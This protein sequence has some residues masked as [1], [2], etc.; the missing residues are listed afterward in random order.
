MN[1]EDLKV[2]AKVH[3]R[4]EQL[5]EASGSVEETGALAMVAAEARVEVLREYVGQLRQLT[6]DILLSHSGGD[7]P[8]TAAE[9][10]EALLAE[11]EARIAVLQEVR[12]AIASAVQRA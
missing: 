11:V 4:L 7:Q 10:G 1:L 9:A 6:A 2:V 3:R 8:I 5:L 12:Q